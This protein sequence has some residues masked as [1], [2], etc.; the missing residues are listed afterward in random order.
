MGVNHDFGSTVASESGPAP[1]LRR[2]VKALVS[3]SDGVLLVRE[4]HRDGSEFWT[5][6][7]GGIHRGET[8]EDALRREI[9]EELQC[10]MV[11]GS[12]HSHYPYAHRSRP[13]LLSLYT[14]YDCSLL[15]RPSPCIEEGVDQC[16]WVHPDGL[17]VR[18]VPQVRTV[19][20]QA[21]R[22][23]ETGALWPAAN[24]CDG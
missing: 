15:G 6:P 20:G 17:P 19:L 13:N 2:G 21:D 8:P 3:G 12:S 5:L 24:R 16:R 23:S 14:V 9:H 11:V 1:R 7:G 10:E 22:R 18:T 4:H